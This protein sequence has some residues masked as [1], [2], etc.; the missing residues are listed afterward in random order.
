MISNTTASTATALAAGIRKPV[1]EYEFKNPPGSGITIDVELR[2][3]RTVPVG[4]SLSENGQR[5]GN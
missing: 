5:F 4:E 1:V 3:S 2:F